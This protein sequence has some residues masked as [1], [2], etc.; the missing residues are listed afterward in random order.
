M[1][2]EI[3][4][5][6]VEFIPEVLQEGVLYISLEYATATH[7][8]FCGCGREVVTPITPTDWSLTRWKDTVSLVP[9]IGN[10]SFP[11][12][13]HYVIKRNRLIWCGDMPQ[14]LIEAG[15]RR[16]R[17]EKERYYSGR[18][19][20]ARSSELTPVQVAKSVR[21]KKSLFKALLSRLTGN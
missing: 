1:R 16:D 13:S 5:D 9:S 21:Q 20:S 4:P 12:R 19:D 2:T 11:C 18:S 14:R 7:K 15:R 10:W 8:C 6:F 3:T 17:M